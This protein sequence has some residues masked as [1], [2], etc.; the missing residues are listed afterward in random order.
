MANFHANLKKVM[1][2]KRHTN[3]L[4]ETEGASGAKLGEKYVGMGCNI[5]EQHE[6]CKN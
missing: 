4:D 2:V 3:A 5:G 6:A 1:L